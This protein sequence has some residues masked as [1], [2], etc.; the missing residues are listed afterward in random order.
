VWLDA[1]WVRTRIPQLFP[2]EKSLSRERAAVWE[3]YLRY[4]RAYGQVFE[5]LRGEYEL[6]VR[7]LNQNASDPRRDGAVE[8]HLAKHLM[9]YYWRGL[10]PV[11]SDGLLDVFFTNASESIRRHA[12][13]FVGRSLRADKNIPKEPLDLLSELVDWRIAKVQA[14]RATSRS[15]LRNSELVEFGWWFSSGHFDQEWALDR[16]LQI[17][18][19][20]G[21]A[22]PDHLVAEELLKL[23]DA[24]PNA[25]AESFRLMVEGAETASSISSWRDE[26]R[27]A[28]EQFLTSGDERLRAEAERTVDA[29]LG[30]RLFEFRDLLS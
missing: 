13:D 3:T 15:E 21:L 20:T 28:L 29:L 22:E 7:A 9:Q 27:A 16:L 12:F 17:L 6:A 24:H 10:L 23:A 14:G 11:I 1:E 5:I 30:Q 25:V 26:V 18:R 19:M 4:G 8:E 2:H